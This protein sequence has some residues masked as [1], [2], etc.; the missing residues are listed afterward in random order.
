[1]FITAALFSFI[2]QFGESFHLK[3]IIPDLKI[4]LKVNNWSTSMSLMK[5]LSARGCCH[6]LS[7]VAGQIRGTSGT[8]IPLLHLVWAIP[9]G[10]S[11]SFTASWSQT[12]DLK[13]YLS[14]SYHPPPTVISSLVLGSRGYFCFYCETELPVL[15]VPLA[16]SWISPPGDIKTHPMTTHNLPGS[17]KAFS[18]RCCSC[19]YNFLPAGSQKNLG[20]DPR[21]R[22]SQEGHK[23][24]EKSSS[25]QLYAE[26]QNL[27][28]CWL[29]Y[30][31]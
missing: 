21:R 8:R 14:T 4:F 29:H 7:K 9:S 24:K 25:A 19:G 17:I 27:K 26:S 20:A 18:K 5:K 12:E 1:M 22:R 13:T 2:L 10:D 3:E 16:V 23:E 11:K 30:E 15:D 6:S 31:N 28:I